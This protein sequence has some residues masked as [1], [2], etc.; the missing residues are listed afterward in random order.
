MKMSY[1]EFIERIKEIVV[2]I[3]KTLQKIVLR[4]WKLSNIRV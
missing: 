1:E 2:G 3:E 4:L